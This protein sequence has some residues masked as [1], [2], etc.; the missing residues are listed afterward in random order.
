MGDGEDDSRT[1]IPKPF[2]GKGKEMKIHERKP[3]Y[4]EG[5]RW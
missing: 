4:I 1:P 5:Q 3:I 2:I